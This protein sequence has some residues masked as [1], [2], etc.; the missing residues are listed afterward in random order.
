M[1]FRL[2]VSDIN[3]YKN[4][5]VQ[6]RTEITNKCPFCISYI[7]DEAHVLFDCPRCKDL[8]PEYLKHHTLNNILSK[9]YD[10]IMQDNW[11][12]VFTNVLR[13]KGR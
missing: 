10:V 2:G 5:F 12:G 11:H 9:Y 6:E 3:M 7:D 1:C 4:R 13:L 8:C